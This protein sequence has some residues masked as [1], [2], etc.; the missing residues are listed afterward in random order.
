M[1]FGRRGKSAD[2][3]AAQDREG[4]ASKEFDAV[5][6]G[7]AEPTFSAVR[8]REHRLLIA[9]ALIVAVI[10][11]VGWLSIPSEENLLETARHDPDVTSRIEAM[12]ALAHRGYWSERPPGELN[13]FLKEQPREVRKFMSRM[14]YALLMR[15]PETASS[16]ASPR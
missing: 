10:A 14:H 12:N 3:A 1:A 11:L 2:S 13:A 9:L 6:D 5:E 8:R 15:P 16:P 4:T 7:V